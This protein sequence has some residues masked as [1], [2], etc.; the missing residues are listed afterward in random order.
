MFGPSANLQN[1]QGRNSTGACLSSNPPV[2]RS[3][4]RARLGVLAD[5]PPATVDTATVDSASA[6]STASVDSVIGNTSVA[7]ATATTAPVA[8]S[9]TDNIT[10]ATATV[11]STVAAAIAT[12]ASAATTGSTDVSSPA[13]RAA[14][15]T[16]PNR[17]PDIDAA[18]MHA[19]TDAGVLS[20][21][22]AREVLKLAITKGFEKLCCEGKQSSNWNSHA[23][24]WRENSFRAMWTPART[25]Y[26]KKNLAA[27][28]EWSSKHGRG[29]TPSVVIDL[30]VIILDSLMQQFPDDVV[31][32]NERSR[33]T[34]KPPSPA[35]P[36]TTR[37]YLAAIQEAL[38][39]LN[40]GM[41]NLIETKDFLSRADRSGAR[42]ANGLRDAM[43]NFSTAIEVLADAQTVDDMSAIPFNVTVS[44][45]AAVTPVVVLDDD[46]T[47]VSVIPVPGTENNCLLFSSMFD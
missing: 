40:H 30:G 19:A 14:P 11:A 24:A 28:N 22:P 7:T 35:V 25:A 18:V 23:R 39:Q 26:R 42:A 34:S 36:V 27:F 41:F 3:P 21:D 9:T 44:P 17:Y 45:T 33:A 31:S 12:G 37:A 46:D 13:G 15:A 20:D 5:T 29:K 8:D 43:L 10:D 47:S 6:A 32:L 16:T 2:M 4:V 1:L 38:D